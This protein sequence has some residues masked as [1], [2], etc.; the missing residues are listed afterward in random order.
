MQ[1]PGFALEASFLC[2]TAF[3]LSSAKPASH[4]FILH[5][6]LHISLLCYTMQVRLSMLLPSSLIPS[7]CIS[8]TALC[9]SDIPSALTASHAP[10]TLHL[11]SFRLGSR[12]SVCLQISPL[13]VR[14][15]LVSPVVQA[16]KERILKF[17]YPSEF[18]HSNPSPSPSFIPLHR[19]MKLGGK[20]CSRDGLSTF[21]KSYLLDLHL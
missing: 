2:R 13:S 14:A 16:I 15:F 9:R 8:I 17:L 4:T 19:Y 18:R 5:G 1:D 21:V 12:V 3:D 11:V 6:E 7:S 20:G 10:G